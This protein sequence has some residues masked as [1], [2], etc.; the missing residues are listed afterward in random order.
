MGIHMSHMSPDHSNLKTKRCFIAISVQLCFRIRHL[1][2]LADCF[3]TFALMKSNSWN[4]LSSFRL[5]KKDSISWVYIWT[6]RPVSCAK[7]QRTH[8]DNTKRAWYESLV[9]W[10]DPRPRGHTANVKKDLQT[11]Y[12]GADQSSNWYSSAVRSCWTDGRGLVV[13]ITFMQRILTLVVKRI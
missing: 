2:P 4:R 3:K 11:L 12:S 10:P 13:S 7:S 9:H 1:E 8:L 6:L 5:L